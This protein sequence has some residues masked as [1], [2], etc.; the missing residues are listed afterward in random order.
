MKIS[1]LLPLCLLLTACQTTGPFDEN[2]SFHLLPAGSRLLLKQDLTIPAHSAG[3]LLQGGHVTSSNAVNRYHPHCRLEV[4]DVRETT[5]T[6]AAD[7]F[8]VQR[9][10]QET[11]MVTHPDTRQAGLRKVSTIGYFDFRTIL[12]LRSPRQPRVRWL[13]CN[14]W[15]DPGLGQHLSVREIR[16]AL[17][18]IFTL[19]LPA[20]TPGDR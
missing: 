18:D 12:D 13:T 15:G 19:S 2:S 7:E 16:Q 20:T 14:Q 3:V 11:P 9:A 1:V 8:V 6:V 17:G 4:L 5:Q 10:R